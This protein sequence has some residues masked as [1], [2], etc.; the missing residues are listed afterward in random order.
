MKHYLQVTEA[1][2]RRAVQNPVQPASATVRQEM[3]E[4]LGPPRV[5]LELANSGEG[6]QTPEVAGTGF[7]PVTSR[8]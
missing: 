7:E 3:T 8:L 2:F 5:W 1:D 6:S 4:T